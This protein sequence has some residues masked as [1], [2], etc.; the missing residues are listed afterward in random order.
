[1][2]NFSILL[3]ATLIASPAIAEDYD[4]YDTYDDE[5]YTTETSKKSD[6]RDT[7]A[8]I[9]L[10]RND[11]IAFEIEVSGDSNK[12]LHNDN[13]GIGLT[14]GNR[15]TKNVKLEFETLYTGTTQKNDG[16]SYKYGVW[17]SMLN[18]Y[19]YKSYGGAVEPYVGM[20]IGLSTLWSTI[21][22]VAPPA[23]TY[24]DTDVDLSFAL[25]TGINFALNEYVDLN[26]GF[27]YVNYGRIKHSEDV[28]T[29]IDA[30]EIYIG[31]AYKFSI[32]DK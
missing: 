21:D 19:L 24:K 7:Y 23:K 18:T 22:M 14:L 3:L 26:F 30:T 1:M 10:H 28:K 27:R 4:D 9:R 2:K 20:G 29:H 8:G 5:P 13:F 12:H 17:S 16:N 31:G 25:M 11:N 32:F 15:L 6:A